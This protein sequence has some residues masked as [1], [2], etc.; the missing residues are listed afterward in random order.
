MGI[1][2]RWFRRWIY[3]RL[4]LYV[5]DWTVPR[6]SVPQLTSFP[7]VAK[8]MPV[9]MGMGAAVGL[10]QGL[11]TLFGGRLGSFKEESDEFERKEIIRRTTRIP[12]E[13]TIQEV[14]EGRG[15]LFFLLLYDL[16]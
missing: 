10:T 3:P 15:M 13:Q 16:R 5:I 12:V 11:F 14:G 1:R 7:R 4:A 2:S 9:V 8:R 6:P